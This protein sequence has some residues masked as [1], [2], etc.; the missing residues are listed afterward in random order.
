MSML[1]CY[2]CGG[3]KMMFRASCFRHAGT[4]NVGG[5]QCLDCGNE[6]FDRVI[7]SGNVRAQ[8]IRIWNT[9]QRKLMDADIERS[10]RYGED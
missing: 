6:A 3:T 7:E 5:A 10:R 4:L 2:E 1:S 9:K 8:Q